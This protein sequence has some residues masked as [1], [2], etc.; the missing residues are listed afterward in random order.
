MQ[1]VQSL[2]VISITDFR[3]PYLI[4]HVSVIVIAVFISAYLIV[5]MNMPMLITLDFFIYF[6][7]FIIILVIVLSLTY[8]IS[9]KE[10]EMFVKNLIFRPSLTEF[11]IKDVNLLIGLKRSSFLGGLVITYN[12][13]LIF[14]FVILNRN[15]SK[16]RKILMSKGYRDGVAVEYE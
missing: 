9:F 5:T 1:K 11:K 3:V 8:E 4:L 15:I 14:K 12:N 2:R 7:S 13:K 10:S 16:I 6:I